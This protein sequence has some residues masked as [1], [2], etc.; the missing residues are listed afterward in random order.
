M[1]LHEIAEKHFFHKRAFIYKGVMVELFLLQKDEE[2]Y[3][4]NFWGKNKYY[5]PEN[6]LITT[7]NGFKLANKEALENYRKNYERLR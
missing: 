4:T 3:Y 7:M 5:W 6:T 1:D 2:G